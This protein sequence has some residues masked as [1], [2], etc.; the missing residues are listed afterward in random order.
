M[1]YCKHTVWQRR[2]R[3]PTHEEVDDACSLQVGHVRMASYQLRTVPF[4]WLG[5][6]LVRASMVPRLSLAG[7]NSK[8]AGGEWHKQ[9]EPRH[10]P[11]LLSCSLSTLT[12]TVCDV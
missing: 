11:P 9:P 7:E 6:C 5:G 3:A 12:R 2:S 10:P 8:R 1:W 4:R